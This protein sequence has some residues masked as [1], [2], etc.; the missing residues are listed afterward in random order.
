MIKKY[1]VFYRSEL[2]SPSK[3]FIAKYD[4]FD[5]KEEAIEASDKWLESVFSYPANGC[6]TIYCLIPDYDI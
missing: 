5:T 3:N 2:E 4:F 1:V 6:A